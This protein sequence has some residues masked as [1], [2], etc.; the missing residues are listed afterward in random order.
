M[1]ELDNGNVTTD[2]FYVANEER[3]ATSGGVLRLFFGRGEEIMGGSSAPASYYYADDHLGSTR[4][5]TD[6]ASAVKASYAYDVWGARTQL[7]AGLNT[8]I[9]FTGYWHHSQSGLEISPT[10]IYNEGF[11]T[12]LS[13]DPLGEQTGTNL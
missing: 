9:G 6:Q 12:W 5:L 13:R 10:R 3:D 2:R 7:L 4:E 1:T 11:G 8:E